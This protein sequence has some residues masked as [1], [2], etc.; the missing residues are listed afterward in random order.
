MKKE[1]T[2][3]PEIRLL[4]LLKTVLPKA[5]S[6]PR[7]AGKIYQA[8]EQELK[9]KS[10]AAAFD[11]FC[12]RLELPNLE[13]ATLAEVQRQFTDAF[14]DGDVTLKPNRK[15]RSLSVEVALPEGGQFSAEIK[16]RP[17]AGKDAGDEDGE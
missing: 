4:E 7:L 10:R 5:T 3:T 8:V 6:D 12:G 16:V 2:K 13:P 14:G 1:K 11:K 9:T 17:T 15:E